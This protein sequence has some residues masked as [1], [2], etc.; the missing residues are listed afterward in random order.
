MKQAGY[1]MMLSE[2]LC[3][4]FLMIDLTLVFVDFLGESNGIS[5]CH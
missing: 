5:W 4:D 1:K 2:C 3:L